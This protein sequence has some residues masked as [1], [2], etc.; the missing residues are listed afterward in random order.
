MRSE[1]LNQMASV[2][3]VPPLSDPRLN[4]LVVTIANVVTGGVQVVDDFEVEIPN[5]EGQVWLRPETLPTIGEIT[6]GTLTIASEHFPI[7]APL[8]VVLRGV[9][10]RFLVQDSQLMN[11]ELHTPQRTLFRV[12]LTPVPDANISYALRYGESWL[13]NFLL[14]RLNHATEVARCLDFEVVKGRVVGLP[15][16][17]RIS[18]RLI[19]FDS[20]EML[21]DD[22]GE[23]IVRFFAARFELTF[24]DGQLRR[25]RLFDSQGLVLGFSVLGLSRFSSTISVAFRDTLP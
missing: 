20:L 11:I 8:T 10:L 17:H 2:S 19:T 4:N 5:G 25:V 24:V 22:D 3:S 7:Y 12:Q 15:G 23:L 1:T 14:C 9:D 18:G 13:H 6:E 21:R 16:G